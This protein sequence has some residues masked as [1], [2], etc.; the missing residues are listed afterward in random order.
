MSDDVN[1]S[2]VE[3]SA[4]QIA[5]SGIKIYWRL[6]TYLKPYRLIFAMGIF[7]FALSSSANTMFLQLLKDLLK[8]IQN[9]N[10]YDRFLI[11]L[12]VLGLT[13]VRSVGTFIG[14]YYLAKASHSV[15]RDLRGQVFSHMTR[16]PNRVFD[17]R[18]SGHLIS[19]IINNVSVVA[20]AVTD[21]L[22][23][24][25]RE[26]LTA[27]GAF[28]YLIYM[29]WKLTM[30]FA[31]IAPFI[32]LSVSKVG[33][34]LRRL[35]NNV[36]I[37]VAD[38]TQVSGEMVNGFRVMRSFGGEP[39]EQ[40][41]FEK[42]SQK[43]YL[44]NMKIVMTAA[45]NAPVIHM[46]VAFAMALLIFLA[47]S[48]TNMRDPAEFVTYLV[49]V[50][51]IIQ[52]LRRLGEVTPIILKGVSA[53]ESVFELLDQP[54]EVDVGEH[55][56]TKA[57]GELVFENVSFAYDNQE[58]LALDAINLVVTPGEVVALVGRSGGGK[59][60]LVNLIPRF[61][62]V[63]RG[64]IKLD[65]MAI[66]DYRLANLRAQIALVNQQ[67]TLF[68]GSVSE[69][70]AYGCVHKVT[71]EDIKRAAD[72]AYA[73]EFIEKLPEGFHT[74]IGEGGTRL[75]GGQRQRLAIARAI[76]KDAPILIMDEATSA[77]DNESE[78]YI[79]SAMDEVMKGRTTFVIAHRLSTIEHA[80][81]ILVLDAGKI[82]EQGT[83]PILLA[84]NGLYAKLHA[85][86]F[87]SELSKS[88]VSKSD[89]LLNKNVSD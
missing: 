10:P 47:M 88:E 18:S 29:D 6:L 41:R 61:Y 14:S 23:I 11:P 3:P 37:S 32:G 77:L 9:N 82:V 51:A 7:G 16:L 81:R 2:K 26:G 44:Q 28:A 62:D 31:L 25:L 78:R 22:K 39:Y 75:S 19:I 66:A 33:K 59:S 34:R 89:L 64:V 83:H 15:I 17:E 40:A 70:I 58:G 20:A 12:E 13:F 30:V 38:I 52:P 42:V 68:E 84:Q 8:V 74:Q 45:A 86:Q 5:P 79:Q 49:A 60:T 21:G 36:Q 56:V 50:A 72:L 76:L 65:G 4:V 1:A 46:L 43:N 53:A 63:S 24:S 71:Q 67:I 27:L 35:N 57:K 55:Q 48:I 73:S 54:A 69:N 87:H 80:H 85:A